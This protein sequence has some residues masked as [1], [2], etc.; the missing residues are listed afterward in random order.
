MPQ[1]GP[2]AGELR[3]NCRHRQARPRSGHETPADE[4]VIRLADGVLDGS[5]F[6]AELRPG[7]ADVGPPAHPEDAHCPGRE[8]GLDV[9]GHAGHHG[10][11]HARDAGH[12][13]RGQAQ[14]RAS[15]ARDLLVDPHQLVHGAEAGGEDVLLPGGA[16]VHGEPVSLDDV[17]RGHELESPRDVRAEPAPRE[18]QQQLAHARGL[19]VVRAE[20]GAGGRDHHVESVHHR[21]EALVL[22]G[23]L[24]ALVG[25]K[26]GERVHGDALVGRP[27]GQMADG[28]ERPGHHHAPDA[29]RERGVQDVAGAEHVALVDLLPMGLGARHLGGGVIDALDPAH[30]GVHRGAVAEVAPRPLEV[31]AAQGLVVAVA[32]GEHAHR[33]ALGEKPPDQIGAKM[34]AASSHE[35]SH[36]ALTLRPR[37][38]RVRCDHRAV[39]G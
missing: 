16:L 39:P 4:V 23:D 37:R 17:P 31:E 19:V 1:P 25:Q 11:D 13:G 7:L 29:V 12:E 15:A 2:A 38:L 14:A 3:G 10:I 28:A 6:E 35:N 8:A 18:V 34:P 30:G 26:L 9:G 24:R 36:R 32:L 27:I 22:D 5:R 20:D 33:L 21:L